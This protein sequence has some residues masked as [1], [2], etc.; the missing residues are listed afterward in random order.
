MAMQIEKTLESGVKLEYHRVTR[1]RIDYPKNEA[2]VEVSSYIN[3]A[4]RDDGKQ[5]VMR[6]MHTI[7]GDIVQS[8]DARAIAYQALVT[9]GQEY[10]GAVEV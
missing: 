7:E 4:A 3:K 5:P 9:E 2:D 10:E 8:G 6:F 1:V